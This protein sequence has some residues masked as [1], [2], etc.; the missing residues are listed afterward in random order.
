MILFYFFLL[1][2][3][4]LLLRTVVASS[5]FFPRF[6]WFCFVVFSRNI[7]FLLPNPWSTYIYLVESVL[8]AVYA[9][10]LYNCPF[11][12][13]VSFIEK[14]CRA[15]VANFVPFLIWKGM[16]QND[17]ARESEQP[18]FVIS[19][20]AIE[21]SVSSAP[22]NICFPLVWNVRHSTRNQKLLHRF[23]QNVYTYREWESVWECKHPPT[24]THTHTL[25]K[26]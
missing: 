6:L 11:H 25:R 22:F 5:A 9:K 18:N 10:H 1:V 23:N 4:L 7:F 3:L 17:R 16:K 13:R 15:D 8:C 12:S 20:F 2:L 21:S 14:I 26:T 19:R 24:H